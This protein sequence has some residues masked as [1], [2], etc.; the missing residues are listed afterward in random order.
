MLFYVVG[1]LLTLGH[2]NY[3]PLSSY[4]LLTNFTIAG[5]GISALLLAIIVIRLLYLNH[6]RYFKS[7]NHDLENLLP[8]YNKDKRSDD[9]EIE[10]ETF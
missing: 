9:E 6:E 7:S 10:T 8:D 3:E 2:Y 1:S 5:E 4:T